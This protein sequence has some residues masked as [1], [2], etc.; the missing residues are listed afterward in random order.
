MGG[1]KACRPHARSQQ[2]LFGCYH[3]AIGFNAGHPAL[4]GQ[5]PNGFGVF[6]DQ[7]AIGFS[8]FGQCLGHVHRIDLTVRRHKEAAKDV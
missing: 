2:H 1:G 7:R 5:Y 4:M 8:P 3:P 6:K